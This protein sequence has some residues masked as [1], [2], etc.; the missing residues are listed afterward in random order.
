MDTILTI[1]AALPA[2]VLMVYIFKK[3]RIEKEPI[4]LLF[5]LFLLGCATCLPASFGELVYQYLFIP[6]GAASVS[7][8]FFENFL[9]VALIEEGVKFIALG[10]VWKNKTFNHL[11]DGIVYAVF[12]SLGFACLENIMY[13]TTQG[14]VFEALQVAGMRAILSVPLHMFCG[15]FMG[16][17]FGIAKYFSVNQR[18]GKNRNLAFALII[19]TLIHGA[20]D[21]A[22]SVEQLDTT[23]FFVIFVVILYAIAF[24]RI[25][26]SSREDR[27]FVSAPSRPPYSANAPSSWV[28][29]CCGSHNT[30]N[31]CPNCGHPR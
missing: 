26:A 14:N 12:V 15:V 13:V 27:A 1:I 20:Y 31:F 28:C 2:V 11:F 6:D 18:G 17:F 24:R 19:P 16:Y 5:A 3:D 4:S 21:F 25:K 23:A 7:D 22:L 29:P 8:T 10:V 30:V 9:G